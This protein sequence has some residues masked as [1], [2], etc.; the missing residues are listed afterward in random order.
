MT[1][2]VDRQTAKIFTL[3]PWNVGKYEILTGKDVLP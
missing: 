3:S 2:I 1:M